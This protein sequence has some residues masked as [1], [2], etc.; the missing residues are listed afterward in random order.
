VKFLISQLTHFLK[1]AAS[2]RNI[3]LL[4][5]FLLVLVIMTT[6]YSIFFMC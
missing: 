5:R 3:R 1:P 2:R 6:V 4:F